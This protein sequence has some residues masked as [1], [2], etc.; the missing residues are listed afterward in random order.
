MHFYKARPTVGKMQTE[1]VS[2]GTSSQALLSSE[3]PSS[4]DIF[5]FKCGN[6]ESLT[7]LLLSSLLQ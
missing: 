7:T 4:R 3:L 5:T 1:D 6:S 2:L